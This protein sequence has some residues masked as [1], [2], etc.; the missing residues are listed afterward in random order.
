MVDNVYRCPIC[1]NEVYPDGC[2]FHCPTKH[3]DDGMPTWIEPKAVF[4]IA[5]GSY[6]YEQLKWSRK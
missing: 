4:N 6:G 2:A 3:R 5:W 1:W